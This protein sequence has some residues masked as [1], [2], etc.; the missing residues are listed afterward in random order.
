MTHDEGVVQ[1]EGRMGGVMAS[2]NEERGAGSGS[3]VIN[4]SFVDSRVRVPSS[5]NLEKVKTRK[6]SGRSKR[7]QRT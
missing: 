2:M 3:F 4:C 5:Q 1:E 6:L 7:V